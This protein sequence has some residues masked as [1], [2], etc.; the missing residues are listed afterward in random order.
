MPNT[1]LEV[2]SVPLKLRPIETVEDRGL[3]SIDL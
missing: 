2:R 3:R 1:S